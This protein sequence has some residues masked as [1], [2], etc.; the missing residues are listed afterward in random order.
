MYQCPVFDGGLFAACA[1]CL[2]ESVSKCSKCGIHYCS[3]TCQTTHYLKHKK[4]CTMSNQQNN[5]VALME[6][7]EDEFKLIG[8]LF[9]LVLQLKSSA[10]EDYRNFYLDLIKNGPQAFLIKKLTPQIDMFK[11]Q[12][13]L[14]YGCN[15][16]ITYLF[17]LA[18]H[19]DTSNL[20]LA[21]IYVMMLSL[22]GKGDGA[23][24]FHY[25]A[26]K[27]L[28]LF[29]IQIPFSNYYKT[30][31]LVFAEDLLDLK[32]CPNIIYLVHIQDLDNL[33]PVQRL[34]LSNDHNLDLDEVTKKRWEISSNTPHPFSHSFLIICQK[35]QFYLMQA[36][37]GYYSFKDW[38][39]FDTQLSRTWKSSPV[40]NNWYHSLE[41]RPKFR[42][43]FPMKN[44]KDLGKALDD[45]IDDK[46]LQGEAYKNITGL[47]MGT[48]FKR[49][50]RIVMNRAN[51]NCLSYL[52]NIK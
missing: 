24:R 8:L 9:D 35:N 6:E 7:A 38:L 4:F 15:A 2:K 40:L 49:N 10:Y 50:F 37:Y 29:E 46:T 28:S 33:V 14:G 18:Y 47:N 31:S 43:K 27:E 17:G 23:M 3:R 36:F 51:L 19:F 32:N 20:M 13:L 52:S 1:N 11:S 45:L 16:S 34:N 41:T 21:N 30:P 39:D 26:P 48:K 44:L 42:G 5:I 22:I 12:K 25:C